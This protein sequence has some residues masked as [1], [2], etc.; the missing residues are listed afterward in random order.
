MERSSVCQHL[1]G[2]VRGK[3]R[4]SAGLFGHRLRGNKG[5]ESRKSL[6][7]SWVLR[8]VE[9]GEWIIKHPNWELLAQGNRSSQSR[10]GS[11]MSALK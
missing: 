1:N 2:P 6:V 7:F 8:E 11:D 4:I 5:V 10:K 9:V 3:R